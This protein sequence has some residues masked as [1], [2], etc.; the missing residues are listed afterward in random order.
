L[1]SSAT[2]LD[3]SSSLPEIIDKMKDQILFLVE[4]FGLTQIYEGEVY[5]DADYEMWVIKFRAFA[6]KKRNV[7]ITER[8]LL[9][10][11]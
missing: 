1:A 8:V 4:Q 7:V 2:K 5:Y 3:E 6:N 10:E 9:I 11:G